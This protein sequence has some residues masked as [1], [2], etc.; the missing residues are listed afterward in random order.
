MDIFH[1][2]GPVHSPECGDMNA[3]GACGAAGPAEPGLPLRVLKDGDLCDAM[4]DPPELGKLFS[5]PGDT[6]NGASGERIDGAWGA[7]SIC[8][9]SKSKVNSCQQLR[10]EN[11]LRKKNN[12]LLGN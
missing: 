11:A 8:H 3:A 7:K 4:L 10:K 9:K 6:R 5:Q 12:I 2:A 1:A